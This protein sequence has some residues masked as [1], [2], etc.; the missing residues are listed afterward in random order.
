MSFSRHQQ[1]LISTILGGGP[2]LS[3]EKPQGH[4]SLPKTDNLLELVFVERADSH[5]PRSVGS[6][7]ARIAVASPSNWPGREAV[8]RVRIRGC[9]GGEDIKYRRCYHSIGLSD[10]CDVRVVLR[11]VLTARACKV[12]LVWAQEQSEIRA[13]SLALLRYNVGYEYLLMTSCQD[14]KR[15]DYSC[16]VKFPLISDINADRRVK[17]R[18]RVNE[19]DEL[20]GK[21]S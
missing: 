21:R 11:I 10:A 18:F 15:T 20:G 16:P 5:V 4:K 2:H 12:I 17:P 9:R 3:P 1:G 14:G 8:R 7:N 13:K 6:S 19:I